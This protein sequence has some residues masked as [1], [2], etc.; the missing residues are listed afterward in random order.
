M[1]SGILLWEGT[2]RTQ[3]KANSEIL[4]I[5]GDDLK[6]TMEMRKKSMQQRSN[7]TESVSIKQKGTAIA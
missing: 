5:E 6:G 7:W 1:L 4:K 3:A 2:E